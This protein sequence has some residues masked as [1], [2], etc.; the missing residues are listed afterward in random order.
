MRALEP[1]EGARRRQGERGMMIVIDWLER[2]G[3]PS[4]WGQQAQGGKGGRGGGGG[5]CSPAS[6]PL[7]G[8]RAQQGSHQNNDDGF[9][10]PPGSQKQKSTTNCKRCAGALSLTRK[11]IESTLTEGRPA[12]H[13]YTERKIDTGGS[14]PERTGVCRR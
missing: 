6:V 8:V 10:T 14:S 9:A 12:I 5:G 4:I 13:I 3:V 1:K 2:P 11:R 7:S